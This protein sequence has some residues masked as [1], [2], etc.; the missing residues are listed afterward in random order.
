M[1]GISLELEG[2]SYLHQSTE[3]LE[4]SVLGWTVARRFTTLSAQLSPLIHGDL[5]EP[6]RHL[7]LCENI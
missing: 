5:P 3:A 2:N 6:D 4:A 7:S 1:S